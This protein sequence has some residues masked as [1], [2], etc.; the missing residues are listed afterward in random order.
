MKPWPTPLGIVLGTG[1]FAASA[2]TGVDLPPET[3]GGGLGGALVVLVWQ[4]VGVLRKLAEA[5]MSHLREEKEHM[6]N[7]KRHWEN[8]E[9]ELRRIHAKLEER[10]A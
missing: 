10:H 4:L 6:K 7:E 3:I 5:H 2:A 8:E 1:A 9:T